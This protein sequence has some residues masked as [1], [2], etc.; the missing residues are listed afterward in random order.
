MDNIKLIEL[1]NHMLSQ[2]YACTIRY[3]THADI[4]SGPFSEEIAER[5]NEIA[6]DELKHAEKLRKR[7]TGLGGVPTMQV[8]AEDL[9]PA[10]TLDQILKVNIAEEMGAIHSYTQILKS[11]SP[12]N[13]IL[14]LAL[15][16]IIADEQE[17]LEELR[18]LEHK[19]Q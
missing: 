10:A 14:Y 6:G 16:E 7:I 9:K 4:I 18:N 17:H 8:S 12:E 5:L 3:A 1:L 11:V 15:Q 2:E 13:A 19:K